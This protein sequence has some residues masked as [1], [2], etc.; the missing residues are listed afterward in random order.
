M[1]RWIA[2]FVACVAMATGAGCD[3]RTSAPSAE[4]TRATREVASTPSGSR[5]VDH[6]GA[7]VG[8]VRVEASLPPLPPLDLSSVPEC[9]RR[10]PQGMPDESVVAGPKG[11]L[12]NVFVYLKGAP[13][14]DGAGRAPAVLDQV[15]CQYVPHVVAVQTGQPLIV[16]SSDPF[17]H[18]MHA[19]DADPPLNWAFAGT[20]QRQT[21]FHTPGF[22]TVRCDVHPWMKAIVGVFDT[23]Y[24]A[25][26]DASGRFTIENVPTGHYTLLAHHERFG[27]LE[28]AVDI[29]PVGKLTVD[30]N[31]K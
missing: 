14:S 3:D 6:A 10:H 13:A 23:P 25:V 17:L 31:Y 11:A 30:F 16:K 15:N 2:I 8:A 29:S 24:F 19:A 9:Q 26:T 12:K 1:I 18:N 20:S 28:Q 5:P 22:V 4:H 21:S 7:I 27:E